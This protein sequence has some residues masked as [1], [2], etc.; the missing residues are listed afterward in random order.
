MPRKFFKKYLPSAES[1]REN[2]FIGRFGSALQHPNLWHLNR[3]SVAGGVAAGLF[4]GL[5]PGSNPVQFTAAAFAAVLFRVNLPV[6]IFVTLYTNPFT[7]VPL[8]FAAYK[9]GAF[10][11]GQSGAAF[12]RAELDLWNTPFS[13]W[14]A[15]LINW[16]AAMGKP[17]ALGLLILASVLAATGYAA[18]HLAWRTYI[19]REWRKRKLRRKI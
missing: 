15:T 8:Y 3:H 5:I 14:L 19:I 1:I 11:L 2:K 13:E 16:M 7:I 17:L 4:T 6:A 9:I 12:P 18:V 10:F